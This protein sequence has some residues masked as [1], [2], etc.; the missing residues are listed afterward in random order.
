VH[1]CTHSGSF[2]LKEQRELRWRMLFSLGD[3]TYLKA[4]RAELV[5]RGKLKIREK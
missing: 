2:P 5:M 1:L 4:H 3:E